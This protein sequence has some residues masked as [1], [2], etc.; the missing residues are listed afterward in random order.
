VGGVV[1]HAGGAD[2]LVAPGS[3]NTNWLPLSVIVS[4]FASPALAL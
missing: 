2:M 3:S 4:L 1:V